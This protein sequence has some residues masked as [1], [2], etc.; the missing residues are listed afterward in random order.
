MK[1]GHFKF[2]VW[3]WQYLVIVVD[4]AVIKNAVHSATKSS[5][6]TYTMASLI[7]RSNPQW[8]SFIEDT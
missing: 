1:E 8:T 5:S 7:P 2:Y 3:C 4:I 6:W